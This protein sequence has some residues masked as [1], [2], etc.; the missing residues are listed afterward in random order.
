MRYIEYVNSEAE[1]YPANFCTVVWSL[2]DTFGLFPSSNPSVIVKSLDF[3]IGTTL[4]ITGMNFVLWHSKSNTVECLELRSHSSSVWI[5]TI[6]HS[7][8]R[9]CSRLSKW[10]IV[11]TRTY[12]ADRRALLSVDISFPLKQGADP[13]VLSSFRFGS[14]LWPWELSFYHSGQK[15]QASIHGKLLVTLTTTF[16]DVAAAFHI[17]GPELGL[18]SSIRIRADSWSLRGTWSEARGICE[19]SSLDAR[20]G[21]SERHSLPSNFFFFRKLKPHSSVCRRNTI[22]TEIP[23]IRLKLR[24]NFI[25]YSWLG[26]FRVPEVDTGHVEGFASLRGFELGWTAQAIRHESDTNRSWLKVNY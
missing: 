11:R 6:K 1:L 15:L 8:V 19:G 14:A 20:S 7:T 3:S 5:S 25:R 21:R 23:R 17:D 26:R 2:E 13:Y 4:L 12:Y 9:S 22:Q 18:L 10:T 24:Q 16:S